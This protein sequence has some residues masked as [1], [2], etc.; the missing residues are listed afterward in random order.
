MLVNSG[1]LFRRPPENVSRSRGTKGEEDKAAY[2]FGVSFFHQALRQDGPFILNTGQ[3]Q[4]TCKD[5]EGCAPLPD[6][7]LPQCKNLPTVH[8]HLGIA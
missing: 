3:G 8:P 5:D 1:I 2:L 6:R 4:L 7:S